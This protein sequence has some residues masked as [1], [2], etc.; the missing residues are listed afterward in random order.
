MFCIIIG[1]QILHKW[2]NLKNSYTLEVNDRKKSESGSSVSGKKQYIFFTELSFLQAVKTN[3]E[4]SNTEEAKSSVEESTT[5][6]VE[7]H[8][9]VAYASLRKRKQTTFKI[10]AV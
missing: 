8:K 9:Q 5:D 6:P 10:K 7:A 3:N 4:T 1:F 2:K